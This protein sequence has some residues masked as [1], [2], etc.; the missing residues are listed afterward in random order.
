MIET[1]DFIKLYPNCS[2]P[3]KWV[4]AMENVLSKYDIDTPER[5]AAFLSQCGHESGGWRVFSENLNY[6]SE[7]LNI[8][9]GK[10]FKRAGREAELYHRQP[11]FIAN[12]VYANRMGNGSTKT[13]DGWKYRGRGPI[14]LTGKNNYHMFGKEMNV[15][16]TDP[17]VVS[18]NKETALLSAIWFWNKNNLNE[19]ADTQDIKAMTK[20]IN[21]GYNGL[22]DRIKHY[23]EAMKLLSSTKIEEPTETNPTDEKI[24][25]DGVL[26]IGS[27]GEAVK[28]IQAILGLIAD[29][30]F[31][32][33]TEDH[34]K[35]WQTNNNLY[36]D[37]I[38]GPL[39]LDKMLKKH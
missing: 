25:I 9:F 34:V 13:G 32:A 38:I 39:T 7:A 27:R 20:K 23:K 37:G 4:K 3:E 29:G 33:K 1:K 14:Q 26:R 22:K 31:G 11:E 18:S 12:V 16:I 19:L 5:I 35:F 6:S 2:E 30:I 21:G 28:T 15:D 8:I 36:A 24:N 17:S 10:Y